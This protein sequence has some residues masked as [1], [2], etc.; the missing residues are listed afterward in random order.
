MPDDHSEP[1]GER[2]AKVTISDVAARAGVSISTVSHAL[3]GKRPISAATRA[4]V[5]EAIA[6]LGYGAN[7]AARSL[8][9]G[10]SGLVGLILRPRDAV[11]GSLR[12]TQTFTRLSGAIATAVLDRGMGLVHVPDIFDPTASRVPM[13]GCIVAH[14]YGRDEVLAELLRRGVPVVT[15]EEDPDRP[16]YPWAVTLDY[17]T[18]LRELLDRVHAEGARRIALVTGTEDN[19]WNRRA[20]EIY[21]AWTGARGITPRHHTLYEG[22]GMEG[23]EEFIRPLLTGQDPPDAVITGPST[24]AA[25]VAHVAGALG[26]SIP[27]DLMLAALT[28]SEF[29]RGGVPPITA[30]DLVLEDLA[31]HAVALMLD[32]MDGGATPDRPQVLQPVLHWRASTMRSGGT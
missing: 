27:G 5:Q 9:T 14:P 23:A 15:V 20:R 11:H 4:R 10:R 28:D 24:F 3:S 19:A 18:T 25:G 29:S 13:D 26:L 16:D 7:P 12:G 22:S 31:R 21:L 32:R 2:P 8:R 6:A 17:G 30:V 1:P